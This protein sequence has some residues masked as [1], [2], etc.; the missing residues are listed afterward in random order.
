[1]AQQAQRR[2]LQAARA[3]RMATYVPLH[4]VASSMA[5]TSEILATQLAALNARG[6]C[7]RLVAGFVTGAEPLTAAAAV[8]SRMCPPGIVRAAPLRLA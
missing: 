6:R 1:M 5:I 4:S 8:M 3:A 7:D 2:P